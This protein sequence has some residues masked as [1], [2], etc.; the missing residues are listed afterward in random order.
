MGF[1]PRHWSASTTLRDGVDRAERHE[2]VT[3][4]VEALLREND[5]LRREV[6]RLRLALDRVQ[7]QQK[8][9]RQ[10]QGQWQ[11]GTSARPHHWTGHDHTSESFPR[12]SREQV[13]RWGA[14]LARQA[15]W[16]ALRQLGLELLIEQNAIPNPP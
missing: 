15:G 3:S 16:N 5:S 13:R 1:D 6:R 7:H 9:R 8:Q 11:Q 14:G 10:E 2:R 4:N 12:V